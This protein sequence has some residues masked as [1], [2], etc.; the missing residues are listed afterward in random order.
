MTRNTMAKIA[1]ASLTIVVIFL[2]IVS[3][4][5]TYYHMYTSAWAVA[6]WGVTAFA[7]I[8]TIIR[9]KLWKRPSVFLFHIALLVILAGALCT[10]TS[11]KSFQIHLRIGETLDIGNSKITLDKFKV[12]YYPAT[13][14]P[15]DFIAR[16]SINGSDSHE[17]SIN[18]VANIDGMRVFLTSCDPDRSG[19]RFTVTQDSMGTFVSYTGY[20]LLLIAMISI[21]IKTK[22]P[23]NIKPKQTITI[24]IMAILSVSN[25]SAAPQTISRDMADALGDLF[26][27]HND[28]VAPLSSLAHDFTIKIYG[29]DTYQGLSSEQ[30]LAGWLFFYDDWKNDQ[31]IKIKDKKSRSLMNIEGDR[32]RL[33]DFFNQDGYIFDTPEHAEANEKFALVSSAAT[34]S[35]WKLFPYSPD[36]LNCTPQMTW[37]SPVDQLPDDIDIDSWRMTRHSFGYLAELASMGKW[38][39]A[40]NTIYKIKKYQELKC[41]ELLPSHNQVKAERIFLKLSSNVLPIILL[42]AIGILLL[43]FPNRTMSIIAL[44]AGMVWITGLICLNAYASKHLPMGNGYETMQWMAMFALSI[45]LFIGHKHVPIM[46]LGMIVAAMALIVALMGQ[47]NPQLTN[48]MP[49]LRSPLLSIHVLTMMLAYAMLA[50]MTLISIMWMCGKHELLNV[51]RLLLLP[52]VFLLAIGIFI[53]AIWANISWGRYWGWD[54]KETWALITMIAYSFPL[55]RYSLPMFKRDKIFAI[56]ILASF[57]TVLMT[58]LGVNFVLGGLHSYA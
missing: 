31:G 35:I 34:G 1:F 27:Y 57:T 39:E 20:I 26:V 13:S 2:A 12:E 16:I 52:S 6:L 10:H 49:V 33:T 17:V 22:R 7:A 40:I 21:S 56:W 42:I 4:S 54:P 32:A 25:I 23:T 58:Y 46:P 3:L 8:V 55:H 28:R 19:C 51:A 41:P 48:L 18:H 43:L 11:G 47:R 36:T 24:I 50:V 5:P 9:A 15:S 53:G 14:A 37:Y 30:V 44:I 45:C 38:Q 29:A